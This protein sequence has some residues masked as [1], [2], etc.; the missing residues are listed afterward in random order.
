MG[1]RT[2]WLDI[3]A[4]AKGAAADKA[5]RAEAEAVVERWNDQLALGRCPGSAPLP[6]LLGLRALP[7]SSR[8]DVVV[9]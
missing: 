5:V 4:G 3:A 9:L 7:R 6:K 1:I 8:A 2:R